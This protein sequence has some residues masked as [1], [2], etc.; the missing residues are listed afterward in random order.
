MEIILK[1]LQGRS[2]IL[3]IDET[4]DKKKGESTDYVKRQY[5][6]NLGKIET[7]IVAVTAYGYLEGIT[8]PLTF[9]VFKPKEKLK[10]ADLYKT[11]PQIAGEMIE[12]LQ[13][14]GFKFE[15]VLADSLYGE[16][17]VNFVSVLSKFNLN[18][19]LAIR[20]NHAV[21]LPREQKV[22]WNNWRKFERVF[23]DGR[24]ETRYIREIIFG[25]R[26]QQ[27]FWQI[28]TDI[29][30]LPDH[31][32]W[33]VMSN[34]PGVKY[35]EVGNLYGLRTW[36]EYGLKQSRGMRPAACEL[37][38]IQARSAGKNELGWA[39]FRVTN[40]AQIEKWW[41]MVMS[42]YLMV[43]LHSHRLNPSLSSLP[44]KFQEHELWDF[45]E[46]WKNVLNNLHLIIQPFVGFN[47]IKRWLKVFPIP[48]LSLGFPRLISLMNLFDICDFTAY[49]RD[50]CYRATA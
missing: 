15:L 47:F 14:L 10:D 41:E 13:K 32:T 30:T 26:R 4:G 39:D 36:V 40:Y 25:K 20:S 43:S 8:F 16:S 35:C 7:G 2:I 38:C 22:R 1:T 17:D 6:G 49:F 44:E 18:Y 28:T 24:T 27:Q 34:I 45:K 33:Y 11:K 12:E 31:S 9:E 5:I 50:S 48:Q 19:L 3:I 37:E 42:A 23:G 46:G 29:D 21:W